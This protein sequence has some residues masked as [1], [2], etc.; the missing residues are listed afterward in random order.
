M[1]RIFHAPGARSLR[2]IWL[3]EELGIPYEVSR[4][5]LG[6]P[7]EDFARV[8]P[9]RALP[10]IVDGDVVMSESVAIM[11]YLMASYGAKDLAPEPGA[12][13]YPDYLQYLLYGE[14]SLAAFVT[15]MVHTTFLAPED[16]RN[17]F[18][19]QGLRGMYAG[20]L[21]LLD[22]VLA[23]RAYVAGETFT[24]ADISVGYG[25]ALGERFGLGDT[26][27]GEVKEYWSMLQER[28]AYKRAASV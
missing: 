3:C 17:N 15:P 4:E 13:A 5:R 21:K 9:T 28:P 10:S 2:V 12:P 22:S 7:S 27:P 8:S 20:R 24:A 6:R 26:F 25:L 19:M 18:T 11:M 23:E 14:A 1:I 16:Q